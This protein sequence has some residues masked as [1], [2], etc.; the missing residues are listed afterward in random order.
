MKIDYLAHH[1]H[2]IPDLCKI[3]VDFFGRYNRAMTVESRGEQLKKRLGTDTIPLT[4]VA[5]EDGKAI[6]SASIKEHDL[7]THLELTPW[8]ASVIVHPEY[9]RRGVGSRIMDRIDQEAVQLGLAKLY[10]FTPD[11]ED[12]YS[13]LGW[14]TLLED[15]F[16]GKPIVIMEKT[17]S[18]E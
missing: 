14:N 7:K 10:L 18:R 1:P 6:G 15:H 3:H 5:I 16:Q 8:V 4:I 9:R 17:Y 12:F 2:L 13:S 11:Q